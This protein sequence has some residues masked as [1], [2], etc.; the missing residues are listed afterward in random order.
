MDDKHR[1]GGTWMIDTED[2]SQGWK[3]K[4]WHGEKH[5]HG[6][7]SITRGAGKT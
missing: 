7:G 4:N 3:Q 2:I 5:Y 1:S 6:V